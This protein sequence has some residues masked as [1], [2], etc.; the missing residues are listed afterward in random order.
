M[1]NRLFV[2]ID[3]PDSTRQLL[4]GLDPH[5]RGVRWTDRAQMHLTL[6]FFGDLSE[7]VE[8]QLR[9]K[10]SAIHFGAFFI[11]VNGVSSFSSKGAPKIIWIGLG[12]AHPHLFQIHKRVQEAAFAVGIEPELRAWHPHITIARC[13]DVSAQSLRKFLQ[14]NVDFEAGMVRVDAFYLYSSKLTPAGPIHTRELTV[15]AAA[16]S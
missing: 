5:I 1:G 14:A 8:L 4:A 15:T 7:N 3:L 6:G 2:A 12:K 13:R 9:E 16:G 11:V 10:L